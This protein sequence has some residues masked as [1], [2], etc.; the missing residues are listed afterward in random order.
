MTVNVD[1]SEMREEY[2][3]VRKKI[4]FIADSNIRPSPDNNYPFNVSFPA[5]QVGG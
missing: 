1:E 2:C 4:I 3:W 5:F